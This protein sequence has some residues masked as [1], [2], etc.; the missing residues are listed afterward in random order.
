M[1]YQG[2]IFLMLSQLMVSCSI[3]CNKVLLTTIPL[4]I[5][6]GFRFGL[7][8]LIGLPLILYS[9]NTIKSLNYSDWFKLII[10]AILG[11]FLFNTCM[12]GALIYTSASYA[13]LIG[14]LLPFIVVLM[15]WLLLKEK[16]Q[17]QD[18][19]AILIASIGVFCIHFT[20]QE[21]SMKIQQLQGGLL[22]VLALVF[23]ALYLI[24]SKRYCV[25]VSG[26]LYTFLVAWINAIC[27]IPLVMHYPIEI[28]HISASAWGLL[29]LMSL[30]F[31]GFYAFWMKALQYATASRIAISTAIAPLATVAL[32]VVFLNEKFQTLGIVGMSLIILALLLQ[33]AK[34]PMFS[35]LGLKGKTNRK[36]LN[37]LDTTD[38]TPE[39]S[40]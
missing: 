11:G 33:Q 34:A 14:S 18:F 15:S 19:F 1:G 7:A 9:F 25:A 10:Q 17:Q 32:S 30:S 36:S 24:F 4:P 26:L 16:I 3:V 38:L 5:L 2:F 13:A 8:S 6:L 22:I 21:F 12:Y 31:I 40:D 35:I 39:R 23:D 28:D 27:F 37:N 29:F 20:P